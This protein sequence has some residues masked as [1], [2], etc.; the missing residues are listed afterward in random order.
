MLSKRGAEEKSAGCGATQGGTLD[1]LSEKLREK[2]PN[3][4][5]IEYFNDAELME[6]MHL[7]N[8]FYDKNAPGDVGSERRILGAPFRFFKKIVRRLTGWYVNP[9][10]ENQREFNAYITRSV[11]EM[12]RYLDHLQINE[13]ILSTIMHRDLALFRSNILFLNRFLERRMIDFEKEFISLRNIKSGANTETVSDNGENGNGRP[14]ELLESLDI[15][16][17]EQRIHGS[18]KMVRDRQKAYVDHFRNCG[19]IVAIGCGR[20]ELVELLTE[21]GLE[22]KGAE[23]NP[24]L[25]NY[26]RDK[27]LDV[28]CAEPLD[29]IEGI[30]DNSL[31]GIMLSRFAGHKSPSGLMRMLN[32]CRDKLRTGGV[33]VIETPNPFSLYAIASYA[34]EDSNRVHPLHPETLKLLCLSYGFLEPSTMFLNPLPPEEHLGEIDP[35]DIGASL[36]PREGELFHQINENFGKI[37]RILFSHR[38]YALAA[39]RGPRE[40]E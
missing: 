10:I 26:C 15:L 18:P 37:N 28:T 2:F 6:N 5:R 35:A 17:L 38:D 34:I 11:N 36:D 33:L 3:G 9:S 22:V 1:E 30:K 19:S 4:H 20:G 7:A 21:E 14:G 12:K 40:N 29:F 25:V 13:D 39:R 27:G 32:M 16:T 23:Q 24:T 31:D 8:A